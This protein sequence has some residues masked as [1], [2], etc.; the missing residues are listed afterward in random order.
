MSKIK[1][2]KEEQE[3]SQQPLRVIITVGIPASGKNYWAS[4]FKTEREALGE[5]WF[6]TDRD[7]IRA[8]HFCKNFDINNYKFSGGKEK[9]VT[10][11]QAE[12]IALRLSCG[13]N[14]IVADTN[15]NPS[16]RGKLEDL[17]TNL[18]DKV[19]LSYKVIDTP[20]HLCT[21]RNL[22]RT[23]TVPESVLI[24]M[25]KRMRKYMGK[26]LY[27]EQKGLPP[28]VIIDV[29]GT[30][31]DME[32]FRGPFE[33][34]KV[35]FD[36]PRKSNVRLLQ[37]WANGYKGDVIIFTGR[38]GIALED[39]KKWLKVHNVP[40]NKIFI[41]PEGNT[42]NDSIIK[43]RMFIENIHEK[44]NV[45]FVM[46]DRKQVNMMWESLGLDVV[47]VGGFTSDF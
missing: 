45:D 28:C 37:G 20:L 24:R 10:T 17:L 6:I 34:D 3:M 41:R 1:Q 14:V 44:Y 42:E 29:D 5:K 18:G 12:M 46:D 39:T 26:P 8:E 33:W 4:E 23:S 22:K 38:D 2:F 7:S 11:I 19:E 21:K 36:K 30:L 16:T 13:Y 40:Y 31:A 15:L 43:E 27:V 47:N 25:E 32:A 9:Q 35:I